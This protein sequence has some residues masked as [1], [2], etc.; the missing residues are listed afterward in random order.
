MKPLERER[1][2]IGSYSFEK[3]FK[4]FSSSCVLFLKKV[5]LSKFF[6]LVE[7]PACRFTLCPHSPYLILIFRT[8]NKVS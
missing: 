2:M 3:P 6:A 5:F 1:L 4:H 8:E 7:F